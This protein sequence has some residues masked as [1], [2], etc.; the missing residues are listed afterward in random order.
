MQFFPVKTSLTIVT[1]GAMILLIASCKLA[2]PVD[3]AS[4]IDFRPRVTPVPIE[5]PIRT[6]VAKRVDAPA[7]TPLP[8]PPRIKAAA[9]PRAE[10]SDA[11][12]NLIEPRGTLDTFYL[13][14]TRTEAK[15]GVTRVLHY[16]DSPVTADSITA[17][18]RSLLQAQYG[19][20]GH[21]FLLPAKPWAWYSHRGVEVRGSGWKIEPASQARAKD[22]I[23]G[24]G[25]VSFRGDTGAFSRIHLG[26][27]HNEIEIFF[28]RQPGGGTFAIKAGEQTL[29]E[30]NTDGP[31][32]AS[33]WV[34]FPLSEDIR[35]IAI[36]VQSGS[37][38]LFGTSF[39]KN[40]SGVIY[41]SLGLNGA[42]VQIVVRYFEQR[43]WAAQLQH[44]RPD[45]VVINYGTNESM[46]PAYIETYYRKELREVIRRV[47]TAVPDA[48]VLVMSPMD[49]GQRGDGETVPILPRIVEI[50]R[51]TAAEMGCAF[52]NTFE[53]MG[54]RGTMARWYS[55]QPRLV[56]AD[57][58]HPL[59]GGARKVG[60]LLDRALCSG[61]E[62]FKSNR[63]D[64]PSA[65]RPPEVSGE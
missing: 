38:R 6:T 56:S 19:D 37:V 30:V 31:D 60:V 17:D 49:H 46:Y 11:F 29:G 26:S 13:A 3:I 33:D 1:F 21:G 50:Q 48:S 10:P 55:M 16:G 36:D 40:V 12:A 22:G 27:A 24:L 54:G 42:Q 53:A 34:T 4:V 41:N 15:R 57:F 63:S 64:I 7:P 47:K 9:V 25:G 18:V 45:L 43:Q 65:N 5:M 8:N 20:A 35:D 62:R 51:E 2:G 59:P 58:I 23:H 44:E 52:F 14:L 28:L 32:K 61:Y 39:A